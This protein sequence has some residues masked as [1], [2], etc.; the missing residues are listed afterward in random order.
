MKVNLSAT[1][2]R[3]T[4][5][6]RTMTA[7]ANSKKINPQSFRGFFNGTLPPSNGP[8]YRKIIESLQVDNLLVTEEQNSNGEVHK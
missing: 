4:S 1:K 2:A 6:G 3:L 7:Y 8:V 5:T